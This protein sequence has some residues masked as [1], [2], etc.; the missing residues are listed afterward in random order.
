MWDQHG[1]SLK[2]ITLSPSYAAKGFT[3]IT[4][5]V[6]NWW[7]GFLKAGLGID[8]KKSRPGNRGNRGCDR[9]RGG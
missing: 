4:F 2:P 9:P 7:V 3:M 6:Q 5:R 8:G 1:M